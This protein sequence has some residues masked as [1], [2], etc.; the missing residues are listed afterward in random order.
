M[1]VSKKI[2]LYPTNEQISQ[3][4]NCA[5]AA[6]FTYNECLAFKIDEYK[7]SGYSCKV[8]DLIEHIQK[9][10][11]SGDYDWLLGIPEAITKQAIKD[12]D[13]AYKNFYS[14]GNKGFPKFKSKRHAKVSFYQ[15]TDKLKM[16]DD[17][18]IKITGIKVPIRVKEKLPSKVKNPRV[19]YDGKFW[20]LSYAVDYQEPCLK[21]EG[22]II[23]VDLGIK[24]LAKTSDKEVRKEKA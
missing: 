5:G 3:F 9:L 16:V 18:H 11:Y 22:D 15:R 20:Y 6:R 8:Q 23:G 19:K 4:F 13:K 17:N 12:L 2:R 1:V 14:R 24:V 21:T 7:A 10:K